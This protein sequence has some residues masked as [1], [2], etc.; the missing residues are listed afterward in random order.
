VPYSVDGKL[1][2]Q[3]Q[4]RNGTQVSDSVALPVTQAAPSVFSVDY[5]GSG[6]G[7]VLNQDLTV[8]NSAHPAVKGSIVI[9]Y[10]TGEGQT[11]PAGVDGLLANGPV[12]PRPALP[13]TVDVGGIAAE[14]LYAGAAP[15]QVAGVLQVNVRIPAGVPSGDVP[16]RVLVGTAASQPGITVAI[17]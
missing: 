11:L 13:V 5:S 9:V 2:T 7:A 10:A 6:Q 15:T 1:G 4:V 14:V 8:N 12:Y 3:L 17:Q 16:V